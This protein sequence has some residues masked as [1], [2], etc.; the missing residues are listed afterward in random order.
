VTCGCH[1]LANTPQELAF[2]RFLMGVSYPGIFLAAARTVSE[3]YPVQERAFVY[4]LYVSGAT[5]GAVV[6]YPLVVWMTLTWSWR[7]PFVIM[8][9]VG[10]LF[11]LSGFSCIADQMSIHG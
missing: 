3:W 11:P 6:A 8:G 4:G 2:W 5:A 1:A 9:G 10:C 7:G